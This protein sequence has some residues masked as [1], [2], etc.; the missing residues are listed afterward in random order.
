MAVQRCVCRCLRHCHRQRRAC[1]LHAWGIRPSS[2]V[3]VHK[4]ITVCVSLRM[5]ARTQ[6]VAAA[7]GREVS[8]LQAGACELLYMYMAV[9]Q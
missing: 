1:T 9:Q 3:H 4:R 6:E 2:C 7:F 5:R 8:R